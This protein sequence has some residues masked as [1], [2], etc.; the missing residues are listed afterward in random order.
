[1]RLVNINEDGSI[2]FPEPYNFPCTELEFEEKGDFLY[3]SCPKG[4]HNELKYKFS[5]IRWNGD[6]KKW[7]L[8]K[9][10]KRAFLNFNKKAPE[11]QRDLM[12][13]R[14]DMIANFEETSALE[15]K[16]ERESLARWGA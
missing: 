5:A 16:R 6:L 15:I 13:R 11:L 9:K 3:I 4:F 1:M 14:A 12:K 10:N 7:V 2:K 8:P